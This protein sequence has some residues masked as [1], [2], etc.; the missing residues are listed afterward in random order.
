[1]RVGGQVIAH[2][3]GDPAGAVH[4]LQV[5]EAAQAVLDERLDIEVVGDASQLLPD[6]PG[7][8]RA[9]G[10]LHRLSH[11]TSLAL[12]TRG[13]VLAGGKHPFC[14]GQT[15]PPEAR[16]CTGV[17]PSRAPVISGG[18]SRRERIHLMFTRQYPPVTRLW[19]SWG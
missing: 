8:L 14:P 7:H 15:E 1:M 4:Q 19:M 13:A 12:P 9:E 6:C 5:V 11:G 18:P 16:W 17:D 10:V 3:V 2:H